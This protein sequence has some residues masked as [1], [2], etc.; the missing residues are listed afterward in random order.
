[1]ARRRKAPRPPFALPRGILLMASPRG[2]RHS[3]TTADGGTVCGGLVGVPADAPAAA[4]RE[5]AADLVASLAR[6]FHG[7]EVTV[8]WHP[9]AAPDAWTADVIPAG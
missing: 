3:L 6:D 2:W 7:T 8:V 5:A 1:M 4:A 9:P